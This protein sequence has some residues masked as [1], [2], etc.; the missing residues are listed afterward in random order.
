MV[1]Y[2][3]VMSFV[4]IA[5]VVGV[6]GAVAGSVFGNARGATHRVLPTL[7]GIWAAAVTTLT[8]ATR[9]GGGETVNLTLLNVGNRADVVDFLLN[10]AMFAPGGIL[11]ACLTVRWY[12]AACV[13]FLGSLTIEVTQ[14]LTES[15][16]TADINDL[17]SNTLGILVGFACAAGVKRTLAPADPPEHR[18]VTAH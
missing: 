11:L 6:A 14:Y 17:V 1:T 5:L 10:T 7:I 4:A 18:Y 2:G 16:R 3:S 13:G 15:G 12:Q 9:P 8:F